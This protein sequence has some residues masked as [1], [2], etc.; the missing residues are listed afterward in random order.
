MNNKEHTSSCTTPRLFS[1]FDGWLNHSTCPYRGGSFLCSESYAAI[2]VNRKTYQPQVHSKRVCNTKGNPW[3]LKPLRI[4]VSQYLLENKDISD[5]HLRLY[6]AI[7]SKMSGLIPVRRTKRDIAK[8]KLLLRALGMKEST[9]YAYVSALR[10]LGLTHKDKFGNLCVKGNKKLQEDQVGIKWEQVCSYTRS[11][12]SIPVPANAW[13]NI[14]NMHTFRSFALMTME[15]DNRKSTKHYWKR[16]TRQMAQNY[17]P[18][19]ELGLTWSIDQLESYMAYAYANK[20]FTYCLDKE[21]ST[22][23]K[24][25]K[26]AKELGWLISEQ[27]VI[28][29]EIPNNTQ[30]LSILEQKVGFLNQDLGFG[31]TPVYRKDTRG[32]YFNWNLPSKFISKLKVHNFKTKEDLEKSREGRIKFLKDFNTCYLKGISEDVY[33]IKSKFNN[34]LT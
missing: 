1:R 10:N 32:Y 8:R 15:A 19:K 12:R 16:S 25:R 23:S 31:L 30:D 6:L 11:Q 7:R 18:L 24:I 21:E 28:R 4:R 22:V 2:P 9:F 17:N 27:K 14:S 5:K 29:C 26:K 13:S 3:R 20:Y 34:S 33:G